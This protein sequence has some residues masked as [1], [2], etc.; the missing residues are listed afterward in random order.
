[1]T[2][3][4]PPEP[5]ADPDPV[6]DS[7]D[8]LNMQRANPLDDVT[9]K[10]SPAEDLT[11]RRTE[12]EAR[13]RALMRARRLAALYGDFEARRD[14]VWECVV[15]AQVGAPEEAVRI[16]S[17]WAEGAYFSWNGSELVDAKTEDVEMFMDFVLGSW[18]LNRPFVVAKALME[19]CMLTAERKPSE[20]LDEEL[21]EEL[22]SV[23]D[24]IR[25]AVQEVEERQRR[26]S[27]SV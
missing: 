4:E 16:V 10:S 21:M 9:A 26:R 19:L 7:P 8:D 18:M 22:L 5:I 2:Q 15:E 14:R 6:V 20:G 3:P 24:D 23:W 12:E 27:S 11:A 13:S 1:V 17:G 25:D